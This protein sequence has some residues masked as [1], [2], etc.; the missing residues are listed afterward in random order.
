MAATDVEVVLTDRGWRVVLQGT[1]KTQEEA[2]SV[3]RW[4]GRRL[5]RESFLRGLNGRW[6]KR[7]SHGRDPRRSPN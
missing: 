7:D 1:Y 2:L 4:A 6:R 5:G 3:A